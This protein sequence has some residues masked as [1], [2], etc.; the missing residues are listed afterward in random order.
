MSTGQNVNDSNHNPSSK[1]IILLEEYKIICDYITSRDALRW[2]ILAA[3]IGVYGLILSE[4][5]KNFFW[6][7]L[8]TVLLVLGGI[9]LS[10]A[11]IQNSRLYEYCKHARKRACEIEN[12]LGMKLYNQYSQ[13]K[14]IGMSTTNIKKSTT[15]VVALSPLVITLIGIVAL[16][17]FVGPPPA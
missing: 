12:L 2:T 11:T 15:W 7:I 3:A 4:L 13:L 14:L 16:Y 5:A 8:N 6:S 17:F 1:E 10:V 9:I